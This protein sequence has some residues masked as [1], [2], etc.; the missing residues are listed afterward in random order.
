MSKAPQKYQKLHSISRRIALLEGISHLLEWDQETYMPSDGGSIR[1]E[2]LEAMAGLIHERR[3]GKEF[4]SALSKLIDLKTG[5]ILLKNLST[6]QSVALMRWR[7]DHLHATALPTEFVEEFA[8]LTSQAQLVWRQARADNAYQH[9]APFLDKIISMNRKKA[10]FLGYKDHPYD[11]LLDLYEPDNTNKKTMTLFESLKKSLVP[12]LKKVAASKQISN[13]FLFGEFNHQKQLD[14]NHVLLDAMGY[15]PKR[16]R[17][18]ISAHPFSTSLHPTDSRIT[19]RIHGKGLMSSIL[20]TL[21]EGGHA[22]YEQGLPI[23]HFGSPLGEAISLGMHESQSRWWETRIGQSKQFWQHQ[24]PI[25]KKH[26]PALKNVDLEDFYKAI[27]RVQ[28]S[29]IRVE[30]DE[31]TYPLHVVL[32]TELERE[33]I[34]GTLSVRELPEAWNSKM[35]SLVGVTPTSN[36]DGCLQDVHWSTGAFGY[37]PTYVLGNMYAAHLFKTFEKDHTDWKTKVAAGELGFIKTWLNEAVY[38]Y[39]REYNSHELLEKITGKKFTS[40]AYIEYLQSK[41]ADVYNLKD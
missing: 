5:E 12:L 34:E 40:D 32:R 29:L 11:A 19:T 26:F 15:L 9:F 13:D 10:E 24:L 20:S 36:T 22:L 41:Y 30:A 25:L 33:L 28:P 2:Q 21:H 23:E 7:R 8:R 39:G 14:Y 4:T 18:D 37:F 35:E 16:G 31:M 1:G 38:K 17:L 3:T 6:A 27:N